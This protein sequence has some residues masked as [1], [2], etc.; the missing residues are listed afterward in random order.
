MLASLENLDRQLRIRVG[1]TDAAF[2]LNFS[3]GSAMVLAQYCAFVRFG[4]TGYRFVMETM[5]S[6][7]EELANPPKP[8]LATSA[9]STAR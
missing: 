7:A 2:T 4:K 1:K 5:R 8:A 6:N 9:R 3:T